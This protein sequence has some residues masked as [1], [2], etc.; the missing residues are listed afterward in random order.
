MLLTLSTIP[1]FSALSF[2]L[3]ASNFATPSTLPKVPLSLTSHYPLNP[4]Q[5]RTTLHLAPHTQPSPI[6]HYLSPSTIPSALAK[7]QQTSHH[8]TNTLGSPRKR[9]AVTPAIIFPL[10]PICSPSQS[11]TFL[12]H[13]RAVTEGIV[14]DSSSSFPHQ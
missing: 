6:P 14:V 5:F 9:G 10:S 11:F 12:K 2:P 13:I 4:C 1:Q 8:R 3:I 7:S